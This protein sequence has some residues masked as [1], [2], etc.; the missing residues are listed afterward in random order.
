MVIVGVFLIIDGKLSVG[1]LV[2][3][4]MLAGRVLAP[5]AGIAAVITRA[6]QSYTALTA[7]NSDHVARARAAARP[8]PLSPERST[9]APS[10]LK[11]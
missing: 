4:T 9:R 3:A 10:R 1:A 5:I 6:S 7:I 11:T 2:A 8:A